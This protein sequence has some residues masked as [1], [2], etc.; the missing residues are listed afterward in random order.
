MPLT[1]RSLLKLAGL[2]PSA[3]LI[4]IQLAHAEDRQFQHALTLFSDVKYGPDFKHFDYVNPLAPK[5]GRVR[6]GIIGSFDNLNPYTYK[7]ETAGAASNDTLTSSSLDEPA[8]KYG[9]VAESMWH[10]QD[11]SLVV[12]RLRPEARFHDGV[13][14]TPDDV[15]WSLEALRAAHPFYNA[16]YK[17]I[18]RAEQTGEREVTFTFSEAGNRELPSIT[19][20]L[21]VLPKHWWTGTDAKGKPRN[22]QETSLEVP[23]ASGSYKAVEVKPGVSFKLK[24]VP[25]YWGRDLPVNVGTDNF[26]EIE[27]VYFRD[28]NV[29]FEAFKGDQYDWQLEIKLQGVGH[30]V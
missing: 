30:A 21:P 22:I 16:Y 28:A 23:L 26:D 3:K 7:G 17:N 29:A 12:Y 18:A 24:R 8:T 4:G 6:F 25:D 19:G 9:L 11:R 2:A 15:I 13:A 20:D 14:M 27:Y 10:P 5:I 1:R